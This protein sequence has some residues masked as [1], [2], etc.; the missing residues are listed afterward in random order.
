M[1]KSNYEFY[2]EASLSQKLADSY[3]LYTQLAGTDRELSDAIALLSYLTDEEN[4]K[5]LQKAPSKWIIGL[6]N[7]LRMSAFA[8]SEKTDTLTKMGMHL[9]KAELEVSKF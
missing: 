7:V 6:L 4:I 9:P 2:K 5:I 8:T 1:S 3:P